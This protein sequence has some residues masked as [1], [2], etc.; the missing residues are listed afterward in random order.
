MNLMQLLQMVQQLH[1]LKAEL[2][3][4]YQ[5]LAPL[6]NITH[7]IYHPILFYIQQTQALFCLLC[8]IKM[9]RNRVIAGGRRRYI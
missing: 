9:R 6:T 7:N 3:R 1:F 4:I 2:R 5:T 8:K